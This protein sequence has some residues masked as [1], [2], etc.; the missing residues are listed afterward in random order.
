MT[1]PG[2]VQVS[3]RFAQAIPPGVKAARPTAPAPLEAPDQVE[4]SEPSRLGKWARA[5]LLAA[6]ITTAAA[7]VLGYAVIHQP[8]PLDACG[9]PEIQ[10]E[11]QVD[12]ATYDI[13]LDQGKNGLA[14]MCVDGP[15]TRDYSIT[16]EDGSYRVQTN[17]FYRDYAVPENAGTPAS[18]DEYR[19]PHEH[20]HDLVPADESARWP[21]SSAQERAVEEAWSQHT[22]LLGN[23]TLETG[24]V[25][26]PNSQAP[27]EE[28]MVNRLTVDGQP[29]YTLNDSAGN[30]LILHSQTPWDDAQAQ[31]AVARVADYR[32]TVPDHLQPEVTSVEFRDGSKPGVPWSAATYYDQDQVVFWNGT[33]NLSERVF[34]HE[35]GHAVGFDEGRATRGPW[36][37]VRG[38]FKEGSGVPKGWEDAMREDGDAVSSYSHR[39]KREDFAETFL[40]Y[41]DASE[42]GALKEFAE[43][44]PHRTEILADL[45][46]T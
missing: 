36:E 16:F 46:A 42:H 19:V 14:R 40:A 21:L 23:L 2:D 25:N 6:G 3:T 26:F 10:F 38:W 34:V 43:A 8:N 24:V 28:L 13:N 1:Y 12:Q 17:T 18:E 20:T 4:L 5:G 44:F 7:G 41:L 33:D 11:Q 9:S 35:L 39:S 45:L 29:I 32:A 22:E 27:P 15:G 30:G 31:D 37:T